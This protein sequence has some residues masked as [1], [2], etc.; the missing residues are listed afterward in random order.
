MRWNHRRRGRVSPAEFIPLAEE[1]NAIFGI[2]EWALRTACR[3]AASGRLP[4]TIAVN[5][6][7]IQ[8]SRDD[9]A[10]M[11]LAILMETGL[12][13]KRLEVE[14]TE[15]TLMADQTR[16]LDSLRKLKAMGG[17]IA[18]DDFGTGYSSLATLH[19]F[20]FDKIKLDQSFVKRLPG[21]AT[22]AAIVRT[23]LAL[24]ESLAVPVL[25]EGIETEAQWQ[26]LAREGCDKGQ[27]FLFARPVPVARL[28]EVIEAAAQFA[29]CGEADGVENTD[30]VVAA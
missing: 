25:A 6:S 18:M 10:E 2:G 11:I 7:P 14:V 5:L 8:F 1:T 12:S 23:V 29:R 17:S 26:F 24:G 16:G 30:V 27:G 9:L 20:P 4:G 22:A 19:A 21:D 15:S 13:P 28:P 3:D